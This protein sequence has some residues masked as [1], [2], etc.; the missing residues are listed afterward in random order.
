MG[1]SATSFAGKWRN[2]PSQVIRVP[3][4][5]AERLMAIARKWDD[6]GVEPQDTY[7]LQ[8]AQPLYQ[9]GLPSIPQ[10]DPRR[11]VNVSSVP[12]LSP[13]RYP[14]G[15]TWLIP[16][17][18]AWLLQKKPKRLF[19]PFAGGAIVSLTAV[20]ENLAQEAVFCELDEGV[21][22]VWQTV[23][24]RNCA[25]LTDQ[26]LSFEVTE[27]S[28]KSALG[29]PAAD[30]KT[31]AFQTILRNRVQRGGIMATGAGLIKNGESGKGLLS[32]W[33]PETLA[34]RL[35][36]IHALRERLH[37]IHGNAFDH[38]KKF[39]DSADAALYVDPPYVKAA[40]RLYSCWQVDHQR[41]F[42]LCSSLNGDTLM[43]YDN[44]DEVTQ[45]ATAEGFAVR[46]ISMKNAHHATMSELLIGKNM[47]WFDRSS[48]IAA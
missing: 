18:R 1:L 29:E 48:A 32:R 19:E 2:K 13:F 38:F 47:A 7:V 37:F 27:Q 39:G 45:W 25:W 4:L 3:V 34:S 33:Y 31:R 36:A 12:Q 16:S 22:A 30:I 14:G 5:M 21:A 6:T 41:I 11:P 10:L 28:V 40:K 42:K 23:L 26:I 24:S 43:S 15:K 44:T 20:A 8:Q 46:P 35:A 9:L 17:I